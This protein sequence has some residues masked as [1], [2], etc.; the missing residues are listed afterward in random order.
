MSSQTWI[1]IALGV[2]VV[3]VLGAGVEF[4]RRV[5]KRRR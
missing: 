5:I 2:Q 3:I 4:L 1:M